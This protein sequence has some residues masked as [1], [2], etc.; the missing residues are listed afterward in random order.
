M[1][2]CLYFTLF[3][4]CS[5]LPLTPPLQS[6]IGEEE[7]AQQEIERWEAEHKFSPYVSRYALQCLSRIQLAAGAPGASQV[8]NNRWEEGKRAHDLRASQVGNK[9]WEEGERAHDLRASQA[10]NNR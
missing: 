9:R 7:R 6:W 10:G 2:P 1:R 3:T 8:G 5:H 4:R